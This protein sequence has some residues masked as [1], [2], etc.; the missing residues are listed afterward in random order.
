M[1][2][3][4]YQQNIFE[5][6]I[7]SSTNDLVQLDTGAGKTPI[8]A[9]LAEYYQQAVIVC[10][11]NILLKQASEKLA[12]CGLHHRI[13]ASQEIKKIAARNNIEFFGKHFIN[14]KSH[15]V[16]I[17]ID[18]W[19]SQFKRISLKFDF[20]KRYIVLIDEAH[21]FAEENKWD[22]LQN[23]LN[24]RCIGFSATPFRNDGMPLLK[25]FNGFFDRIVQAEGYKENGTERLIAEG[26][27]AQY[28]AFVAMVGD[29]SLSESVVDLK[30]EMSVAMPPIRAYMQFGENKQAILIVPRILNAKT[31]CEVLN[32]LNIP[33]AVIH[34][35][36][37][38][39]EI[40]RILQAFK[41]K[42]IK[43]L[44]AVDMISEGFD[45]PDADI[46]LLYRKI[47]SFGLYRQV[48][49][50]VLRPRQGKMAKIID[51]TGFNIAKHGL[52]SDHVDWTER[53]KNTRKKPLCVCRKCAHVYRANLKCCPNCG[54]GEISNGAI[55]YV[56]TMFYSAKMI[57]AHRQKLDLLEQ[58][59]LKEE[60]RIA[61][62]IKWQNEYIPAT[63]TF[64]KTLVDKKS[65]EFFLLLCNLLKHITTP[66]EYNEFMKK[67]E[68]EMSSL[69]FYMKYFMTYAKTNKK[70]DA[71]NAVKLLY[72][73]MK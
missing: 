65:E 59:R 68:K 45:V 63:P 5:Q 71:T 60:Q 29:K 44:V 35:E 30:Q 70:Q 42:H 10:H 50:R 40:Q 54:F 28:Q 52:P 11:R 57:E 15:I 23:T 33:A 3:R 19:N 32:K 69:T 16:L 58:E 1:K 6:L 27:L 48:C 39:Y 66:L 53:N 21:H 12:A 61:Y 64:G 43:I 2:L 36:L 20:S 13:L 22:L 56:K 24:A 37:P 17:S 49:G 25:V 34:S 46:L 62:K 55:P 18:T 47:R 26:Y 38:Q 14:P 7:Q 67:H 8:I 73:D 72:G 31:E 9:K 51:L 41:Q 4:T